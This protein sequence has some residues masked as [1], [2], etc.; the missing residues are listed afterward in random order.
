MQR[1]FLR[2]FWLYIGEITTTTQY[3]RQID[4]KTGF[5]EGKKGRKRCA[6]GLYLWKK[7][8]KQMS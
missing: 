7:A 8:N 5:P 2:N 1:D 6:N 4:C 3:R